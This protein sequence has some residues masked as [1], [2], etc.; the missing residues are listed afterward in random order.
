[1]AAGLLLLSC[2]EKEREATE[3]TEATVAE[4]EA[5]QMQGREAARPFLRAGELDSMQLHGMLLEVSTKRGEYTRQKRISERDAFDSTFIS[6]VRTVRPG[7]A[8]EIQRARP[9]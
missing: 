7:L 5:A 6:T 1:M 2:S 9:E 8:D 3:R 4:I